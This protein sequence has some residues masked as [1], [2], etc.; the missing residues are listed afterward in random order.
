MIP[1]TAVDQYARDAGELFG[2]SRVEPD[3]HLPEY[4]NFPASSLNVGFM[5]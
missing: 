5:S 1:T 2:V 3:V 4:V